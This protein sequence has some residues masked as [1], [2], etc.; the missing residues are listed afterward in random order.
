MDNGTNISSINFSKDSGDEQEQTQEQNATPT[1]TPKQEQ[2]PLAA[3]RSDV[4]TE[5]VELP[6]R[7]LLYHK[8]SPLSSGQVEIKYMTAKEE[9]IISTESYIKNNKVVEKLLRSLI[10]TKCNYNDLLLGDKNAIMIAARKYGYGE[11]YEA[12]VR[13]P[14]G[15]MQKVE[16]NL[17]DIGYKGFE[18]ID[19]EEVEQN[20]NQFKF[21][22][23]I[24]KDIITFK[25]MTVGDDNRVKDL[26]K[27]RKNKKSKRGNGDS[28]V[29]T[30][31]EMVILE[32]NGEAP[33]D[34][35]GYVNSMLARDSRA[36]RKYYADLQPDVDLNFEF[37]DEETGEPFRT[38]VTIGAEFLYP[39]FEG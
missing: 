29:T 38:D 6:S 9:D 24:S 25:F 12:K 34:I 22:L 18:D 11:D 7:G 32:I 15:K 8:S 35:E 2:A 30:R 10:V 31:I 5:M 26:L 19:L 17:D 20:G 23:P 28:L 1:S 39:D 36:F 37:E 4:P 13:N 27:K 21:Q 16:I 14:S 33:N 3:T